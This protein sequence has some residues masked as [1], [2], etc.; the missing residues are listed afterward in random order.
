MCQVLKNDFTFFHEQLVLV[1]ISATI[2]LRRSS[3]TFLSSS[4]KYHRFVVDGV[5]G[6][7]KT[8]YIPMGKLITASNTNIHLNG[9]MPDLLKRLMIACCNGPDTI[10]LKLPEMANHALRLLTSSLL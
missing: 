9:G 1:L 2:N 6:L 3:P 7:A 8:V 4:V 5:L 10:P